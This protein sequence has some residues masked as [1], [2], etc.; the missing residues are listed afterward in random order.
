LKYP[1]K[2]HWNSAW[3][4]VGTS[5]EHPWNIVRRHNVCTRPGRAKPADIL[6]P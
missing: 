1:W 5:L 3:R 6:P 2:S 4:M